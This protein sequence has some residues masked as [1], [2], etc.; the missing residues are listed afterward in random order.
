MSFALEFADSEVRD[1]AADSGSVCV[2]FAAASARDSNGERGWLPSVTLTLSDATLLG[3]VALAFGKVAD[4]H[5]RHDGRDI[6]RPALPDTRSGQIEL[7]LR[8][9]NGTHVTA[10]GRSLALSV[11]DDARFAEDLSC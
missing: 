2:R 10:R 1:V 6:A 11:A 9:A 4:G 7:A 3:D 8:F 5:L